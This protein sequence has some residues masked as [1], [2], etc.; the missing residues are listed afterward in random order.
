[1]LALALC[2]AAAWLVPGGWRLAGTRVRRT[3]QGRK[4]G[5]STLLDGLKGLTAM[6]FGLGRVGRRAGSARMMLVPLLFGEL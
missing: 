3:A 5:F 1:M 6:W 2:I 4:P